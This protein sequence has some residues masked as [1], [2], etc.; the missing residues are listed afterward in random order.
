MDFTTF[1]TIEL[2]RAVEAE[3]EALR[4]SRKWHG[5]LRDLR[6]ADDERMGY[7]ADARRRAE[8]RREFVSAL[9]AAHAEGMTV[10]AWMARASSPRRAGAQADAA[11]SERADWAGLNGAA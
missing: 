1:T 4:D 11:L 6:R 7:V 3:K 2:G 10:D 9:D 8:L 5:V